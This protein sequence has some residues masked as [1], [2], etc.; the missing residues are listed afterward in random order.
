MKDNLCLAGNINVF[1]A[2]KVARE[3]FDNLS[4]DRWTCGFDLD[5][6]DVLF[7]IPINVLDKLR[8][9]IKEELLLVL[10]EAWCNSQFKSLE[11]K[12]LSFLLSEIA[13]YLIF[14][15]SSAVLTCREPTVSAEI[16]WGEKNL[17]SEVM[18]GHPFMNLPEAEAENKPF[19][20]LFNKVAVTDTLNDVG[21]FVAVREHRIIRIIFKRTPYGFSAC[22]CNHVTVFG[23]AFRRHKVVFAVYLIHVRAFKVAAA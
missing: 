5:T 16:Y 12:E 4:L 6:N 19:P 9:E 7:F 1:R 15:V 8:E 21:R 22:V 23:T 11:E 17:S 3:V 10:R 14:F 13:F 20:V 2:N 18:V